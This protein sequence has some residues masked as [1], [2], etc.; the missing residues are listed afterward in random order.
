MNRLDYYKPTLTLLADAQSV[1]TV[2]KELGCSVN[3]IHS[4]IRELCV[5]YGA[6]N[7]EHLAVLAVTQGDVHISSRLQIKWALYAQTRK[8]WPTSAIRLGLLKKAQGKRP[9]MTK[10]TK[11]TLS[12]AQRKHWE[13]YRATR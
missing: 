9:P 5:M 10:A 13:I 2:A 1:E 3:T 6:R 7:V 4:R 8:E 12:V 11:S